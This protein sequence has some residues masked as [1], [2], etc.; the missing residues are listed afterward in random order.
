[1][2]AIRRGL[3]L[4][5]RCGIEWEGQILI[6]ANGGPC[7]EGK[8]SRNRTGAGRL[9]PQWRGVHKATGSLA[10]HS[11]KPE[12]QFMFDGNTS[13]YCLRSNKRFTAGIEL[14]YNHSAS[15]TESTN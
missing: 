11:R 7:T 5:K 12:Y 4:C 3:R 15:A 2:E 10:N 9:Y 6:P 14:P 1:M 8:G 13:S